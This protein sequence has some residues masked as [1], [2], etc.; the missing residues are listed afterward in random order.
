MDIKIDPELIDKAANEAFSNLIK[1]DNY[2]SPIKQILE[3]EFSYDMSGDGKSDLAKQLK[4]KVDETISKLIESPD[5]HTILG[6]E[7]AKR[8]AESCVKDLRH[9]KDITKR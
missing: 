2:H 6:Q 1:S 5:F 3:R 4:A 8:F 9:L 7:I